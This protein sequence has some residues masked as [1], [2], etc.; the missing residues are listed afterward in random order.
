MAKIGRNAP[1]YCGSGKKYKHC[2]LRTDQLEQPGAGDTPAV[3]QSLGTK[4]RQFGLHQRFYLDFVEALDLF[5]NG[6]LSPDQFGNT[7]EVYRLSFTDYFLH[8]HLNAATRTRIIDL[9]AEAS[10]SH[11]NPS[12]QRVL[13]NWRQAYLSVYEVSAGEAD[14]LVQLRDIFQGNATTAQMG[15]VDIEPWPLLYGRLVLGKAPAYFIGGFVLPIPV[16]VKDELKSFIEVRYHAYQE[17]HYGGQWPDFLR[18]SGYLVH[19]FL[20]ERL[21]P[22]LAPRGEV[23]SPL[24]A[25]TMAEARE[26]VRQMQGAIISGTLDQ[27]YARWTETPIER[28]GGK[29]PREMVRTDAGRERVESVLNELEDIERVK[30]ETG[31]LAYDVNRLRL[32][33]GLI[34]PVHTGGGVLVG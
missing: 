4:L 30:A 3:R 26:I 14:G 13:D 10:R 34:E 29:T 11:L 19:H 28:W 2:H 18:D 16:E 6:R 12:E 27:H 20:I 8:D 31:Q 23:E 15:W 25:D 9:F 33:L 22:E 21:R 32:M 17:R 5:W 24:D 1:C 7:D